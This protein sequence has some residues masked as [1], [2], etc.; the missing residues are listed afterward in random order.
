MRVG[1]SWAIRAPS[2]RAWGLRSK[3]KPYPTKP[4]VVARR[5]SRL[6]YGMVSGVE[7]PAERARARWSRMG[8]QIE[9]VLQRSAA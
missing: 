7:N 5:S 6:R 9:A 2:V 4:R 1:S 8:G 3:S